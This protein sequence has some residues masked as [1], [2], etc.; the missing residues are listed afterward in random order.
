MGLSG[1]GVQVVIARVVISVLPKNSV[2]QTLHE[3]L[4]FFGVLGRD[5]KRRL[6]FIRFIFVVGHIVRFGPVLVRRLGRLFRVILDFG[7]AIGGQMS[8][9]Q[10]VASPGKSRPATHSG[11]PDKSISMTTSLAIW[12]KTAATAAS[13]FTVSSGWGRPSSLNARPT[14]AR[15]ASFWPIWSRSNASAPEAKLSGS[16]AGPDPIP[17]RSKPFTEEFP[18]GPS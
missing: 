8:R 3:E 12:R 13:V 10:Y 9:R 11:S 1:I 6:G 5:I 17:E 2:G 15:S 18:F 16:P 7:L 14:K 4:P